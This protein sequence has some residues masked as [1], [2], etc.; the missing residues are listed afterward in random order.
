MEL[1]AENATLS[2]ENAA[3]HEAVTARDRFLA[4]AAHELR[5][6]M[7]PIRGRVQLLRQM[8]RRGACDGALASKMEQGLEQVEWLIEQYVKRATTLLDDAPRRE[9]CAHDPTLAGSVLFL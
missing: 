8:L 2:R 6:P 1:A 4:V 7:T 9:P 3:L 5:N